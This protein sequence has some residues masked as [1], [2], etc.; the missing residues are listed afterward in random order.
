M[1]WEAT[2]KPGDEIVFIGWPESNQWCGHRKIPLK[3]FLT[4]GRV[5][6]VRTVEM[7]G[8]WPGPSFYLGFDSQYGPVWHHFSGFRP[9]LFDPIEVETFEVA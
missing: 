3:S 7:R 6:V 4:I 2:A 5:Y 9:V 8:R 1:G